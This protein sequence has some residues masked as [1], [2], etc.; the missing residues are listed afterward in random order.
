MSKHLKK[1]LCKTNSSLTVK[2]N[3]FDYL[4]VTKKYF[5]LISRWLEP[6]KQFQK[7]KKKHATEDFSFYLSILVA[8]AEA[9]TGDSLQRKKQSFS[10]VSPRDMSLR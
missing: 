2:Y 6:L 10:N 5:V 7:E 8:D 4:K 1:V 9:R 3:N